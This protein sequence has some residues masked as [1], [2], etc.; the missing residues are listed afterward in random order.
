MVPSCSTELLLYP[1]MPTQKAA[2]WSALLLQV[3]VGSV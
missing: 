3:A 1:S 2:S